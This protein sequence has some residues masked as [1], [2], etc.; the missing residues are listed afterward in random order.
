MNGC[1]DYVKN[2]YRFPEAILVTF[3]IEF[4][5]KNPLNLANVLPNF[6]VW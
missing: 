1:F 5:C 2:A 4:L 3:Y 6:I